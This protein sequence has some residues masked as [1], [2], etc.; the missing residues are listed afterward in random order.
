MYTIYLDPNTLELLLVSTDND[1]YNNIDHLVKNGWLTKDATQYNKN[2]YGLRRV[3]QVLLE[4][5][6][7][8]WNFQL[9]KLNEAF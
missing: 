9:A 8:A 3:K 6:H 1:K 5:H 2:P 7:Y 4:Y